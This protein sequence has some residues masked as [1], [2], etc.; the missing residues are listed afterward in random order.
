[1]QLTPD[2][3]LKLIPCCSLELTPGG[4]SR[5]SMN[6]FFL[7]ESPSAR[8]SILH[9]F[10]IEL[11]PD[12]PLELTPGWSF[13]HTPLTRITLLIHVHDHILFDSKTAKRH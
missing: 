4:Y 9:P 5:M 2:N 1:M 8:S 11:T 13:E 3:S 7:P 10:K 12:G 6:L